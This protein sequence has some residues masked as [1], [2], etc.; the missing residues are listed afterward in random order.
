MCDSCGCGH[1]HPH[2]HS[3]G[4]DHTPPVPATRTVEVRTSAL[5]VNQRYADENRGWFRAKGLHV[6]NLLSSP[7]SGKTAL[8]EKT[9]PRLPHSAAMVG[10]LQTQ[11]DAERLRNSGAQALQITT[12]AT[13]HLDA[14]MVAHALERLNTDGVNILF[15][16]NVG[17]LVCPA[18]YDLG[19]A[20]RIVLLSVTEGEDKPLKYPVIFQKA[21]LVLL[22]KMDL[23]AAVEFNREAAVAHLRA[24]APNAAVLDVSSKTGEGMEAWLAWLESSA[25]GA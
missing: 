7:G 1:S 2:F 11:R 14:H 21:D 22:T 23:A 16:E 25:A 10:D 4:S 12:G 13:C 17:N 24:V 19:E 8:L 15:I 5:A 18:S 6:F 20:K 9:L 3:A